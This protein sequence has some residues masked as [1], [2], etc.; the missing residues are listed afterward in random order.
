MDILV[1]ILLYLKGLLVLGLLMACIAFLVLGPLYLLL[2]FG[3]H[4]WLPFRPGGK[5]EDGL[6]IWCEPIR[7]LGGRWGRRPV[8]W[9]MRKMGFRGRYMSFSWH[10]ALEGT[11][12]LPALMNHKKNARKAAE[13]AKII[14]D[15]RRQFPDAPIYLLGNSSGAYIALLATELLDED[16]HVD[17]L[18][19][20]AGTIHCRHDLSIALRRVKT[21]LLVS[22]SLGDFPANGIATLIF[23]AADRRHGPAMGFIGAFDPDSGEAFKHP[24]FEQLCWRPW[25]VTIGCFGMHDWCMVNGWLTQVLAP[26]L[27]LAKQG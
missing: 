14:T 3:P 16:I 12:V 9:C 20:L 6:L 1:F 8:C 27:G 4:F 24:K 26:K 25:M 21:K 22:A 11:L 2:W 19:L 23:G 5:G 7:F 13:L 15:Q 18:S 17:Y 10:N